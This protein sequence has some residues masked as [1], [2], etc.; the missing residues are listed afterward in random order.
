MMKHRTTDPPHIRRYLALPTTALALALLVAAGGCSLFGV[1]TKGELAA[2]EKAT[3]ERR[4]QVARQVVDLDRQLADTSAQIDALERSL[5]PRLAALTDSVTTLGSDVGAARTKMAELELAVDLTRNQFE[6][7]RQYAARIDQD[8]QTASATAEDAASRS[9]E[10]WQAYFDAL[11]EE[12]SRLQA[13]LDAL[14]EKIEQL[15]ARESARSDEQAAPAD[16]TS[17]DEQAPLPG[18]IR[19]EPEAPA[20]PADGLSLRG[21]EAVGVSD[22]NGR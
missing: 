7:M 1:A 11:L 16:Q 15:Q 10:T 13:R 4:E 8:T 21:A 20:G 17:A 14:T 9:Q 19:I 18:E 12:R 2:M 6:D 5:A 22:K 3:D